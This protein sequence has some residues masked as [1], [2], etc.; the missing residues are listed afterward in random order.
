MKT[1]IVR[2]SLFLSAAILFSGGIALGESKATKLVSTSKLHKPLPETLTRFGACVVDEYLYVSSG[3]SGD[4]HGFGKDLLVD[5]FRR[6]KFDDPAAEWEELAMHDSAQSTAI[7]TDGKSI[8]RIGG[9]SFLKVLLGIEWQQLPPPDKDKDKDKGRDE[10]AV[11]ADEYKFCGCLVARVK[12][13]RVVV[14]NIGGSL[15]SV[16]LS[17]HFR[18][19]GATA[20]PGQ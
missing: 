18:L 17:S 5:H 14:L 1:K 7:V 16:L 9:L 20:H 3:H 12:V 19:F 15:F 8:Y 6:I 10:T 4:V 13:D 11:R 2:T